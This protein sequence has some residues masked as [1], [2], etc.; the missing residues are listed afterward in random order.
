MMNED[1]PSAARLLGAQGLPRVQTGVCGPLRRGVRAPWGASRQLSE[2]V[3]AILGQDDAFQM[4]CQLWSPSG[5]GHKPAGRKLAVTASQEE[6][7]PGL[8]PNRLCCC[9]KRPL[10]PVTPAA[11]LKGNPGFQ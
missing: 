2:G 11:C 1:A 7:E 6:G 4:D 5:W 10:V 3:P 9:P 8:F